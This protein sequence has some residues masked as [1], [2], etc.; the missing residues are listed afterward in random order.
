MDLPQE[1][2]YALSNIT[3]HSFYHFFYQPSSY[4]TLYNENVRFRGISEEAIHRWLLQYQQLTI[5]SLLNSRGQQALINNPVNTGRIAML[6]DIFPDAH[7][8]YMARNPVEVYLATRKFFGE[9][10]TTTSFE[11]ITE[12]Q[13]SDCTIY[14]YRNMLRDYLAEKGRIRSE[15]LIE[16]RFEEFIVDPLKKLAEIYTKFGFGSY[17]A[18]S[19]G[20]KRY[21]ASQKN[22]VLNRYTV[23]RKELQ[24]VTEQLDFAMKH[25]KYDL[26][27]NLDIID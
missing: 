4:K 14:I 13:L 11:H 21:M 6:L 17:D 15:R 20:F 23:S 19:P 25:F 12:M 1:D 2:E 26:P 18:M 9:L 8:I 16:I 27:S 3:D 24:F 5:K 10:L 7:F 22:H